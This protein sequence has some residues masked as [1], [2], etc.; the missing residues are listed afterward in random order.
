MTRNLP[1]FDN[2]PITEAVLGVE[3]EPLGKWQVPHYGLYWD[4][5]KHKYPAC[6]VQP[7]LSDKI[8]FNEAPPKMTLD[9]K[10]L[11]SPE[12]RCWYIDKADSWLIQLQNNRFISNWRKRDDTYPH[13]HG[14]W[15]RFLSEWN[16]FNEFLSKMSIGEPI[17]IQCEVTYINHIDID[18]AIDD[19][20]NIFPI[21][22]TR[23]EREFLPEL[24]TLAIN[25]AFIIPENRGRL[26]LS[27]Q[28]VFR[29]YDAKVILQMSA[30]AKLRPT[31]KNKAFI[32]EA[33][34]LGHEW[35]VRGFADFTSAKMH[36]VW[37][38]RV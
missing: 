34:D 11:T 18:S 12:V 25:T 10:L 20:G 23:F 13:Y 9:L 14:F 33:L 4:R 17:P 37:K 8:E 30:T 35:V 29:H 5:I 24:D 31:S 19:L 27:M 36:E 15:E 6:S 32:H 26:Y 16:R 7:P 21:L 2:P 1:K 28:P 38:R 3:F 22:N